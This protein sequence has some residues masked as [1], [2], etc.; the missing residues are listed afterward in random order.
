MVQVI[1]SRLLEKVETLY[2]QMIPFG[3]NSK[4]AACT[5]GCIASIIME[6]QAYGMSMD[7]I[8]RELKKNV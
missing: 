8:C 5:T 1:T 7:S 4:A 3:G 2:G 6:K